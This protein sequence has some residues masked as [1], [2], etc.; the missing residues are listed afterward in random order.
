MRS[1]EAVPAG[2]DRLTETRFIRPFRS[3][4]NADVPAVGG[5]NASLGEMYRALA[6]AGIEIPNG[7]AVTADAYR[8]VVA[9]ASGRLHEMLDG[10][11]PGDLGDFAVRAQQAQDLVAALPLP[12]ELA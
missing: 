6:P 9:Q 11:D 7:F 4:T 12:D 2:A 8:E 5:K 1:L 10:I 3:I